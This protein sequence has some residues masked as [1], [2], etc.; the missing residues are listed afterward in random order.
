MNEITNVTIVSTNLN[1]KLLK[2]YIDYALIEGNFTYEEL[3]NKKKVIFFNVLNNLDDA[4]LKKL[5]N[6]LKTNN[7]LFIIATNDM[8]L[9]L[10]TDYLIVYDKENILIEGPTIEVLKNE[11]LLKRLGLGPP[12]MIDLS[13]LLK[14]Y[15]LV[16]KIYLDKESLVNILWK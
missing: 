4:S 7:I 10:Y 6:Y 1:K 13:L 8:E 11:K 2:K 15:G 9:C 14:D 5:F 3:L 16:D 12:F